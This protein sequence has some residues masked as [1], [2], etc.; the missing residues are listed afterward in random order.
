[1]SADDKDNPRTKTISD[2]PGAIAEM[3][4]NQLARIIDFVPDATLAIDLKGNVIAWNRAMEKLT[5]IKANDIVGKGE[6]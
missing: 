5:G 1:M 6:L 4:F 2:C 3:D